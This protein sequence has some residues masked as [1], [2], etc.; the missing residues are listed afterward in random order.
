MLCYLKSLGT[1]LVV[2]WLRL[3]SPSAEGPGSIPSQK[4]KILQAVWY[5]QNE[6]KN[7]IIETVYEHFQAVKPLVLSCLKVI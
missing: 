6:K 5:G 7:Y 2:H 3:H 4:T 1:S